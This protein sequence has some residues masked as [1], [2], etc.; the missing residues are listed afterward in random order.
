MAKVDPEKYP[1]NNKTRLA[2]GD[3]VRIGIFLMLFGILLC[4]G[5]FFL[6]WYE[7]DWG[8]AYY[9]A[10]YGTGFMSDFTLMVNVSK[11]GGAVMLAVGGI[12]YLIGKKKDP[13]IE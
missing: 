5:G 2:K 12:L 10:M 11:I 6:S 8:P 7:G 9:E 13:V 3:T 1:L 4:A